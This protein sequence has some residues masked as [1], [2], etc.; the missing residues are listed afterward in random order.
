MQRKS[1]RSKARTVRE[2]RAGTKCRVRRQA[3]RAR[4]AQAFCL[5][6]GLRPTGSDVRAAREYL[7]KEQVA[8]ELTPPGFP[9]DKYPRRRQLP[10]RFASFT[11]NGEIKEMRVSAHSE[12]RPNPSGRQK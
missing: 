3:N 12:S 11:Q 8:L 4:S 10:S 7:G 2:P 5:A 1:A 6:S 9:F